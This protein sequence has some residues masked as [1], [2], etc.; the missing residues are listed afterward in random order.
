MCIG[1]VR[2][3]AD[4][5]SALPRQRYVGISAVRDCAKSETELWQKFSSVPDLT[6]AALPPADPSLIPA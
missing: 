5:A 1:G 6:T 2:D 4:A 3:T